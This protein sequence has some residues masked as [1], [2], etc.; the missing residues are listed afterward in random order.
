MFPKYRLVV[1][2]SPVSKDPTAGSFVSSSVKDRTQNIKTIERP[3]KSLTCLHT[4][5][6]GFF[7]ERNSIARALV[8]NGRGK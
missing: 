1:F 3:I 2:G 5:L 4:T 8:R 6:Y 7:L